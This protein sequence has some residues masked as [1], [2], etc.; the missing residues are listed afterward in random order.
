MVG[1]LPCKSCIINELEYEFKLEGT[2]NI[3]MRE[4]VINHLKRRKIKLNASEN[5]LLVGE[6][7]VKELMDFFYHHMTPEEVTFRVDQQAWQA[8]SAIDQYLNS[9]WVDN[10]IKDERVSCHFQPIVD[11]NEETY[12]YEILS[13]FL[14]ENEQMIF[15]NELFDAAKKRGRLY[16]L[17][18][19]CRM[20][21]VKNSA[22]INKKVFI[23]FIP[24]SIYSPEHCL[25]TTVALAK[26]LGIEPHQFVFEVV[27]SEQVE[28]LDH[29]K[30]ILTYYKERGFEYA[31]DDVGAGFNTIDSVAALKP[32]YIKLDMKYVQGVAADPL[33]QKTALAFLH[34]AIEVGATPLAEGVEEREDFEW[35]KQQGYQLF[36]GYLFGKP[37]P[38]PQ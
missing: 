23:N 17:D 22:A 9:D 19:L 35:L 21:A 33:K 28:D 11:R 18:R 34:K 10:V 20:N 3:A 15:P 32:H 29:L 5:A 24:T 6:S 27:E 7:G 14:D 38:L 25:A 1:N 2:R 37:S 12:A 26:K 13:R 4:E 36:Q 16:A 30:R 8:L 31:L